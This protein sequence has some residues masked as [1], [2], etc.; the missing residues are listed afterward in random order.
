MNG[1]SMENSI[2]V[3]IPAY[4]VESTIIRTLESIERQ[5]QRDVIEEVVVVNDGSQDNTK[6]FVLKYANTSSLNIVLINKENA[7]ASSARN[8]GI[9]KSKGKW[10]AFCDADDEWLPIKI[11]HQLSIINEN[12]DIA[13]LGGNW[14]DNPIVILGR[15]IECLHNLTIRDVCLKTFPQTST[16]IVKRKVCIDV[17]G[18]AENLECGEDVR[19]IFDVLDKYKGYYEPKKIVLYDNNKRG[20]GSKGL[21]SNLLKMHRGNIDNYLYLY[22]SK[23]IS[24]AFYLFL[25][26]F[27]EIKYIRRIIITLIQ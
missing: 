1:K 19:F 24:L 8:V 13:F 26:L 25:L 20:F 16:I 21:S 18:F 14:K 22:N 12:E 7:G 10:I 15:K 23:K 27:E 9:R 6:E 3:V 4:N 17:G 5:T 2:S 11:E